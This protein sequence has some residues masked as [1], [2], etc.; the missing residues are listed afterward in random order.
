MCSYFNQF[1]ASIIVNNQPL[2]E[3]NKNNRRTCIVPF[4]SEYKM[5]L[6]NYNNVRCKVE[7]FIDGTDVLFGE[8]LVINPKQT[9][10]L[11]RFLT[12]N[13]SGKKFKFASLKQAEA[14]GELHDP[15]N[16]DN[17]HIQ[18][19]FYKELEYTLT[20]TYQPQT[21][22]IN[23]NQQPFIQEQKT[24]MWQTP[25]IYCSSVQDSGLTHR[26]GGLSGVTVNSTTSGVAFAGA[27]MDWNET[28]TGVTLEGSISN[29]KF[30]EVPDFCTE[31]SP[32]VIDIWLEGKGDTTPSAKEFILAAFESN[33]TSIQI[34]YAQQW[35]KVFC[36]NLDTNTKS[37]VEFFILPVLDNKNS[38]AGEKDRAK[39]WLSN[40]NF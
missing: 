25:H 4:G 23:I 24:P 39:Q 12:D 14:A 16:F 19:K 22:F 10:E 36:K 26:G 34:N 27:T 35:L 7:I 6:K 31:S 8:K 13:N 40:L 37:I 9:L 28:K 11:E 1:V 18:I 29:Q 5:R 20:T 32:S 15:N 17:G 38:S 30:T 3:I 21:T 2:R 33:A